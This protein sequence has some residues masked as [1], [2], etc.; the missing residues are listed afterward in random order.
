[1][2]LIPQ[3]FFRAGEVGLHPPVLGFTFLLVAATVLVFGLVPAWYGTRGPLARVLQNS[4]R[5]T[6]GRLGRRVLSGSRRWMRGSP[7]RGS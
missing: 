5:S 1:M 3:T 4:H 7:A 6:E 2:A